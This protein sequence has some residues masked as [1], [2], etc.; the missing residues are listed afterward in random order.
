[1]RIQPVV[2]RHL[3]KILYVKRNTHWILGGK[4]H[5]RMNV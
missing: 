2:I 5:N 3:I 1:V 4:N